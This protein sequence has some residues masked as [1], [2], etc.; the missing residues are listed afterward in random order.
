M[1][2]KDGRSHQLLTRPT[3]SRLI[4]AVGAFLRS[5]PE[6]C[7]PTVGSNPK[8]RHG[9]LH[10]CAAPRI[11]AAK[12]RIPLNARTALAA[13]LAASSAWPASA[14]AS[15]CD[16]FQSELTDVTC[17]NTATFSLSADGSELT[18]RQ[19]TAERDLRPSAIPA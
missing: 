11:Y 18:V 15:D 8:A 2:Q 1:W 3:T 5:V 12:M 19:T 13:L 16:F 14:Q 10:N 7:L 17:G 4:V 9:H 6:L